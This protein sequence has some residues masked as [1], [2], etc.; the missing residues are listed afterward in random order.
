MSL[1]DP[2][3]QD[4]DMEVIDCDPQIA[5]YICR[6]KEE[7]DKYL[8]DCCVMKHALDTLRSGGCGRHRNQSFVGQNQRNNCQCC[9][10][11]QENCDNALTKVSDYP[12]PE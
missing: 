8:K 1:T 12:K 6:L 4:A 9:D 7:R 3:E 11:V 5:S 2:R 10:V